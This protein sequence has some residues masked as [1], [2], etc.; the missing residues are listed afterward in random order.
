MITI[1]GKNLEDVTAVDFGE[2]RATRVEDISSTT[3]KATA[4]A[5]SAGT[6]NVIV[7]TAGGGASAVSPSDQFTY[8]IPLPVITGL[9]PDAGSAA[10]RTTVT[11]SGT[12]FSGVSAVNFGVA[13]A[14]IRSHTETAITVESP[15]GSGTVYVTVTTPGGTTPSSG[16]GAKHAKFKY[17]KVKTKG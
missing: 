1:T 5:G 12:N 2:A 15:A 8:Y 3:I 17:K 11:I 4:P 7:A 16:K 10:G 9:S 6:T 13:S 14:I